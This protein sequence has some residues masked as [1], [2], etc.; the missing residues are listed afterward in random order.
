MKSEL[1]TTEAAEL[2]GVTRQTIA[3]QIRDGDLPA[4]G[5]KRTQRVYLVDLLQLYPA[6]REKIDTTPDLQTENQELKERLRDTREKLNKVESERD[7]FRNKSE[8]YEQQTKLLTMVAEQRKNE[9]KP[10]I[11]TLGGVAIVS[12]AALAYLAITALS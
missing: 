1:S 2:V 4:H 9:N 10:F 8:V 6:A 11:Y 7:M 12:V 5:T 3:R